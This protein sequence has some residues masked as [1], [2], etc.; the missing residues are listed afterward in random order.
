M[1]PLL[2]ALSCPIFPPGSFALAVPD[3]CFSQSALDKYFDGERDGK[4]VEMLKN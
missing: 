3:E 1:A 2:C 4:T